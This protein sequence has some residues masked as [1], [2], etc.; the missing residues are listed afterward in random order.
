MARGAADGTAVGREATVFAPSMG[1][2]TVGHLAFFGVAVSAVVAGLESLVLYHRGHGRHQGPRGPATPLGAPGPTSAECGGPRRGG[3]ESEARRD[4]P[5]GPRP[6]P[7]AR[8]PSASS[9]P[10]RVGPG[11]SPGRQ[12]EWKS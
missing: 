1:T 4:A 6:A 11:D 9:V 12:R 2:L 10:G 3:V 8:A 5:P 7:Q